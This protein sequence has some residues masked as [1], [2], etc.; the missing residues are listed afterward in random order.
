MSDSIPPIQFPLIEM[1][2]ADEANMVLAKSVLAKQIRDVDAFLD[3]Y[4]IEWRVAQR[5]VN[6]IQVSSVVILS[7]TPKSPPKEA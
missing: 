5:I 4:R 3:T 1:L 7:A 6:Q 2:T